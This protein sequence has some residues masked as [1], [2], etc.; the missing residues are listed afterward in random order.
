MIVNHL[1][2]VH[3]WNFEST[4]IN[5]EKSLDNF[6]LANFP[7]K[8][9]ALRAYVAP[10]SLWFQMQHMFATLISLRKRSKIHINDLCKWIIG[11]HFKVSLKHFF[12]IRRNGNVLFIDKTKLFLRLGIFNWLMF[13]SFNWEFNENVMAVDRT[14]F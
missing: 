12:P 1:Y 3:S 5:I 8:P 2:S 7:Q 13:L 14:F 10:A 11:L 4:G 6:P 9:T